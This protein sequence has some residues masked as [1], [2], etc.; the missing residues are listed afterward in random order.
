MSTRTLLLLVGLI[1]GAELFARGYL[2]NRALAFHAGAWLLAASLLVATR[3]RARWLCRGATALA[4]LFALLSAAEWLPRPPAPAALPRA[5]FAEAGGDPEALRLWWEQHERER[6][7]LRGETP[8]EPAQRFSLFDTEVELDAQVLRRAEPPPTGAFRIVVLGG[9]AT[10]GAPRTPDERPWPDLLAREIENTYACERPVAVRNAGRPGRTLAELVKDFDAEIAPLE[11]D[12]LV[13]YA[14]ADALAGLEPS[15]EALPPAARRER[16]SRWLAALEAPL[17]E[18]RDA[19][20][21]RAA[22]AI[23]PRPESLRRSAPAKRYR[24]LLVAARE[25]GMDVALVPLALA[26]DADSPQAALRFHEA[27][28]PETRR[29]LVANRN[30]ALLLPVLGVAYR[31]EVLDIGD[32]LDGAWQDGFLDLVHFTETGS[33]RLARHVAR[34][35]AP[36]LSRGAGCAPRVAGAG[37]SS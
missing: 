5:S 27:V 26:V 35:L 33:E 18:L 8:L 37:G 30:H 4:A 13:V 21:L 34:G 3:G 31:A 16:A 25:Q 23:V 14:G 20:R 9:S 24:R 11:P 36:L 29:L 32:D 1:G 12:L 6:K 2:T 10:F 28:W 17:R 7:L 22:L 15:E 19:R